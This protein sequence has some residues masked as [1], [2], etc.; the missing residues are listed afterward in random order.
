MI[1]AQ[2]AFPFGF[3]LKARGAL[4]SLEA[5]RAAFEKNGAPRPEAARAAQEA[6]AA[7][8][9]VDGAALAVRVRPAPARG[10]TLLEARLTDPEVVETLEK[11]LR[12]LGALGAEETL[13]APRR[14]RLEGERGVFRLAPGALWI[15]TPEEEAEGAAAALETALSGRSRLVQ[16]ISDAWARFHLIGEGARSVL[17]KGAALDL[18]PGAFGL[19]PGGALGDFRRLA[20]AGFPAALHALSEA[21]ERFE[22]LCRRSEAEA[23]WSWLRR[24]A[25]AG[26]LPPIW[27]EH[28]PSGARD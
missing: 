18:A 21:P 25:R 3:A 15:A 8:R 17:A 26:A 22:L 20:V 10:L 13:P 5:G 11:A 14:R 4:E 16:P 19:A 27:P 12:K 6:E 2:N 23:L 28:W 7:R 24:A 1:D 9:W